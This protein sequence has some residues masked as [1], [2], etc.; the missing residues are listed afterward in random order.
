MFYLG[1]LRK[2]YSFARSLEAMPVSRWGHLLWAFSPSG[3]ASILFR[4]ASRSRGPRR[5]GLVW[6]LQ[7]AFSSFVASGARFE[8]AINFPHPIGIVIGNGAVLHDRVRVFQGVTL[9]SD[10]EGGYP[11]VQ[12]GV[13]LYAGCAVVGAVVVPADSSVRAGYVLS[14]RTQS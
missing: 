8:G 6:V 4:A 3:A 9:G 13:K 10:G 12:S 5:R 11:T 14:R 7:F 1:W 2:D